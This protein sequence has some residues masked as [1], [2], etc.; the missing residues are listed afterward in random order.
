MNTLESISGYIND[1]N[2][3]ENRTSYSVTLKTPEGVVIINPEDITAYPVKNEN[4]DNEE[5]EES[6]VSNDSEN[7]H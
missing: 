2:P 3:E 5:N 6:A 7:P 1:Y 4:K